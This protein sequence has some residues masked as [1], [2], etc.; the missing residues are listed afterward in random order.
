M[1][2]TKWMR[3]TGFVI[4]LGFLL[5]AMAPQ[6][7]AV[8]A[9]G[10]TVTNYTDAGG[11]NWTA[12]IFTSSGV[13][14]NYSLSSVEVLVV[15]GGGGG[16]C[17]IG[18]GGG[19]G[20]VVAI[21]SAALTSG[22]YTV[23]VGG[24]GAGGSGVYTSGGDGGNGTNSSAF[25]VIAAGG[26]GGGHFDGSTGTVGKIGGSGGGAGA[27]STSSGS[28]ASGGTT[29][30]SASSLGG[31]AGKI[32]EC[33]GGS[34][35]T[36]RN[37]VT[38]TAARGGGGAGTNAT[39]GV[40]AG[41]GGAGGAG[42]TNAILGANYYWG[43]GGGGGAFNSRNGG[44]G[45]TGGGGGGA[46]RGSTGGGYGTGGLTNGT[47][48]GAGNGAQG[49]NGGANTGGG[50][51]GGTWLDSGSSFTGGGNGGSGIV[52][53][54][55]PTSGSSTLLDIRNAP[56][57]AVTTTGATFN[58][59]L[60]STGT[61][62]TAVCVLWGTNNGAVSGAW[63][64]TNWWNPGDWTNGSYP[65]TNISLNSGRNYY[66]TF[67]ASNATTNVTASSPQYLITGALTVQATT[68]AASELG[69]PGAFTVSRPSNC[70]NEALVV[71]YT[72]GGSASSGVDYAALS[73]TVTIPASQSTAA[74]NVLPVCWDQIVEGTETV[75]VTLAAGP[76]VIGAQS[77]DIVT[78]AD[79]PMQRVWSGTGNWNVTNYWAGGIL[80]SAGEAAVISS[81]TVTLTNSTPNLVSFSN[82]ATVT[83]DSTNAAIIATDVIL[84]GTVNH[85]A[86]SATTTNGLGQWIP[87]SRVWF[88][89]TNLTLSGTISVNGC[90]FQG[91]PGGQAGYGPGRGFNHT[92]GGGGGYGGS[93]GMENNAYGTTNAPDMPGSGAAGSSWSG[94]GNGGGLVTISASG[95]V[96]INGTITAN[97]TTPAN[98]G[99]GSGGGVYISANR[100][101][102]SGSIQADGADSTSSGNGGGGGG[103]RIAVVYDPTAQ[104]AQ[105]LVAKPTVSLSAGI[106]RR[107]YTGTVVY[108]SF[109]EE[110]TVYLSDTSFFPVPTLPGSYIVSP[111]F[112]SWTVTNLTLTKGMLRFDSGFQLTVLSNLAVNGVAGLDLRNCTLSVG[113]TLTI[114]NNDYANSYLY[115]GTGSSCSVGSNLLLSKGRMIWNNNT[116]DSNQ[117]LDVFVGGDFVMTN[118]ALLYT[119][120]AVTNSPGVDYGARLVVTGSLVVASNSVIYPS[121]HAYSNNAGGLLIVASNVTI[122]AGAA[123]NA[124]GRGFSGA[125]AANGD[126]YGPGKGKGNNTGGGHGGLGG[127]STPTSG[128]TYD[129]SNAPV[130]A[131]S[132]GGAT[133]WTGGAS[134]GGIIRIVASQTLT[135]DGALSANGGTL[136]HDAAGGGAGGAINLSCTELKGAGTIRACGLNSVTG[137]GGGG[138]RIAVTRQY[139]YNWTGILRD[140]NEVMGGTNSSGPSG[141]TG[142]VAWIQLPAVPVAANVNAT[143]LDYY[144]ATLQGTLLSTGSAPALVSVFWGTNDAGPTA[145]GWA[146]TNA[147]A[148]YQAQGA[149]FATNVVNLTPGTRYYYRFYATNSVG[150][151]WASAAQSFM[152]T[153]P[154]PVITNAAGGASAITLTSATLNGALISTG[155]APTV[156][157]V[158][159]GTSD[160]GT[161]PA[162]WANTNTLGYVGTGAVARTIALGATNVTYYYTFG[163]TNGGGQVLAT[164]SSAFLGGA[165]WIQATGPTA[166]EAP[167]ITGTCTVFRASS[168]TG[169]ALTVNLA[170]SGSASNGVDYQYVPSSVLMPAGVSNVT[171]VIAPYSDALVEGTETA[172]V[173]L[174][175]GLYVVGNPSNGTVSIQD[176]APSLSN[177]WTGT[178]N[179]TNSA[180]W[181]SGYVPLDGQNVIVNGSITLGQ[182]TPNFSSFTLAAGNTLTFTGTNTVLQANTITI[183]GTVTHNAN[184]ASSAPWAASN[185]V[186]FACGS[187][188]LA[189]N[190]QIALDA[191]GYAGGN[192]ATDG[193][194]P[195]QGLKS[196]TLGGGGGYGGA[197]GIATASSG[198]TYGLTNSPADPGSGG[199]GSAFGT[200]GA[201]GGAVIIA[202]TGPADISGTISAC[203]TTG[204]S[205]GGGGSGG[206]VSIGCQ[207]LTGTGLVR[208]NGGAPSGSGG[209]G[210]GGRIAVNYDLAAQAAQNAV[211]KPTVR[212][213]ANEGRAG[214]SYSYHGTAGTLYFPDA[215]FFPGTNLFGGQIIISNWTSAVFP[216]LSVSQGTVIFP[217][218]FSLT[219]S[220]D[221]TVSGLGGLYLTNSLMSVGRDLTFSNSAYA[222][223]YVYGG[224][225]AT[226]AVGRVLTLSASRLDVVN[227]GTNVTPFGIG[228]DLVLTNGSQW[229]LYSIATNAACTNFG[230]RVDVGGMFKIT[231]NSA[232]YPHSHASSGGAPCLYVQTVQVD[233]GS[234]INADGLGFSRN[235]TGVY[236]AGYGNGGGQGNM[237][238]GGGGYGGV[239]GNNGA[240]YGQT[241]GS[242]NAPAAPG[243]GGGGT[244]WNDGQAGN[245]G[246][247]VGI[248][249]TGDARIDGTITA[250][251]TGRSHNY[252]G[253]GSGGGIMLTAKRLLGTGVIQA[254]GE[255]SV[256]GGGGGGGRI[257]I[258]A[259]PGAW[260]GTMRYPEEVAGGTNSAGASGATGTIVWV[261][262]PKGAVFTFR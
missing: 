59:S 237:Y 13:F 76:Y 62:A 129:S 68:P 143:N 64:N 144:S 78:I 257:A 56:V 147:F 148:G 51:G 235:G 100:L 63:A 117:K 152:T 166:S 44:N 39:S 70:T 231:G 125:L 105:N 191:K 110:G 154:L 192:F 3:G 31:Y 57:T 158:Y 50:G 17:A 248:F 195:G 233:A 245:G 251:G 121:S 222:R 25:D 227:T 14:T 250:N 58:G 97:G 247:Y 73:G 203:G 60:V 155:T 262:P 81:G 223:S 33:A 112:T 206:A 208:A 137:G 71:N 246:G 18:G 54:R 189:T 98:S 24:G 30:G 238:S 123:V 188:N 16:G 170:I 126:G 21:S 173:T 168:A 11:T 200:G 204:E 221:L 220:N 80:P 229:H 28:G 185:L 19:G 4:S 115:G 249:G 156:V 131:G 177:T 82:N 34:V 52:I 218:G 114:T 49:G 2:T 159:W 169:L 217:Q 7:L 45:G 163:A 41:P 174:A 32:Y 153:V 183:N 140:P 175:S 10:G 157:S 136:P 47:G 20:G 95:L 194:G 40:A 92:L 210:G 102:G 205:R 255:S 228:A 180:N 260:A 202:C 172:S 240:G 164:P 138:G 198:L 48:G 258:H 133:Y 141:G 23:T 160:G 119:Y 9:S 43:G 124:D 130:Q 145:A 214:D 190:G 167:G 236:L 75:Q 209:G 84:G 178:G 211:T 162:A 120:A 36:P 186:R 109:G 134:G 132:G 216:A 252:A 261:E 53:V 26:G 259:W 85:T 242:S 89:C 86:N 88:V 165:L 146:V 128:Q 187:F 171:I 225:A 224:A 197:G 12:H 116:T 46:S 254:K 256:D 193:S 213:S 122:A 22:T 72:V 111:G 101:A 74:I 87:N 29:N 215:G 184:T 107:V 253:G 15:G 38:D 91:G 196:D 243:S 201:G 65:S 234:Q 226:V 149:S 182:S 142:T 207:I 35:T 108:D 69:T 8:L 1:S 212:F 67:G 219:V 103:G 151:A 239:G 244:A 93:G 90:G 139:N 96:T 127:N 199:S 176:M 179:W 6:A 150:E 27:N 77:N 94:G 66:Y 113:N 99:G 42:I 232:F 106:G 181:S 37:G 118:N 104:A 55:Y 83:F 230:A 79:A 241:Y 135:M 161:N 61:S 5:A